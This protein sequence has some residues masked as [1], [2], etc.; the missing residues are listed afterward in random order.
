M[1][2]VKFLLNP[3]H[4]LAFG[5]GAGYVPKL[6]GTAG[7][8]VGVVLYL[9]VS[10]LA[11]LYYVILV[12]V[13]FIFGIGLCA[14]TTG[15]LEV[16]D[17]PAIV[18]DEIVGYLVTMMFAPSGWRWIVL[19]FV[20]F[21]IFDIWKPWPIRLIDKQIKGGLGTMAD[22]LIAGIFSLIII[23]VFVYIL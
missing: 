9:I 19:G 8:L 4:F 11:W 7:T 23:Q 16:D 21:R 15:I 3:L 22:D 6:P 20:L 14:Y 17:H 12:L 5:L 18:W 10:D 2:P 1:V 13:L